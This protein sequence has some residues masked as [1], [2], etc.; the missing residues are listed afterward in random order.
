VDIVPGDRAS[1]CEG[2]MTPIRINL[3]GGQMQSIIFKCIKCGYEGKNKIAN[4]DDRKVLM[5]I[6][7][8]EF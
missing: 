3:Q 5:Q 8:V 1:N 4:D 6:F 2:L 7:E